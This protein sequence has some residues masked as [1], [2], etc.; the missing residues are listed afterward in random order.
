[1]NAGICANTSGDF[2]TKSMA[3]AF[4][5]ATAVVSSPWLVM[6]ITGYGA[7]SAGLRSTSLA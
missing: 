1:M 2:T 7:V 5:A 6:I 3:P 4:M